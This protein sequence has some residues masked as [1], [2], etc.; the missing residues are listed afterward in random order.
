MPPKATSVAAFRC[1]LDSRNAA[2]IPDLDDV[3]G[4]D[5]K[6]ARPF[7]YTGAADV[8]ASGTAVSGASVMDAFGGSML[9]SYDWNDAF[10]VYDGEGNPHT[11]NVVLRKALDRPADPNGTPPTSAES[12]WDWYAYYTD[13]NGNVANQYGEGAG[14]LV[15][16]DNGQLKRTY[17]YEPTLATSGTPPTFNWSPVEKIV[18]LAADSDKPTGR[19]ATNFGSGSGAITL[20]FLGSDLAKQLGL[21]D[22]GPMGGVTS[23]GSDYTTK[24]KAQDG[25]PSGVLNSWSVDS[26]GVITGAYSN[27]QSRPIAQLALA[28][29]M[30]PQGLDK[31]GQTCFD[32]SANSGEPRIVAPMEAGAGKIE[33]MT[34][35]MSNVDLSEEFVNLIRSQRGLQA[36]TRAVTTSDQMLEVLIN[37]KR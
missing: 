11:M 7:S 3:P 33:G 26:R 22:S 20:D 27:G 30:N 24:L 16:G 10:I 17:T 25:Y 29:F 35:E 19:V 1:N 36:N 14:T 6:V 15:F 31:V 2:R 21:A 37:L 23:F 9:N 5:G 34:I 8:F 13:E 18:G 4:G 32:V 28:M 12:E